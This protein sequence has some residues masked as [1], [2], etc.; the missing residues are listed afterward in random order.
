METTESTNSNPKRRGLSI[1]ELKKRL[2]LDKIHV[3]QPIKVKKDGKHL[4]YVAGYTLPLRWET[5]ERL[6]IP[7]QR[8]IEEVDREWYDEDF[9]EIYGRALNTDNIRFYRW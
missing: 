4:Y 3:H 8:I 5:I 6:N 2:G 1:Q 7:N 9:F